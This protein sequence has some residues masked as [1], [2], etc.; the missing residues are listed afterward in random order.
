MTRYKEAHTRAKAVFGH[1]VL[2]PSRCK[3]TVLS[4]TDMKR[5]E[6]GL[7]EGHTPW[8]SADGQTKPVKRQHHQ[9]QNQPRTL[10]RTFTTPHPQL[11]SH[12][13][14]ILKHI[15]G[16]SVIQENGVVHNATHTYPSWQPVGTPASLSVSHASRLTYAQV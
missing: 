8:K 2:R 5:G 6:A 14:L 16:C 4:Q 1:E 7:P 15:Q 3:L 10:A 9:Q 12:P 11:R 13:V